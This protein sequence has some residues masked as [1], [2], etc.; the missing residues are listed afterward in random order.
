MN[1]I[2]IVGIGGFIGTIFRYGVNIACEK[3]TSLPF[4]TLIVN[5]LGCFAIGLV[6]ALSEKIVEK[7]TIL[8]LTTGCLGGFTTFS[9]FGLDTFK[10][11]QSG[12]MGLVA[13][14]IIANIFLGI[15]AVWGGR[16]LGMLFS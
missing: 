2:L 13:V 8:F 4:A 5:V 9:A 1:T 14:N 7:D 6:Y 3:Y 12:Q 10:L 11:F 16:S 15:F